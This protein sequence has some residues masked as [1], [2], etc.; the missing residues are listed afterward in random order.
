[1]RKR[2]QYTLEFK[3]E[4]QFIIGLRDHKG[5]HRCEGTAIEALED[6][7]L[8]CLP[9]DVV[10]SLREKYPRFFDHC[11]EILIREFV[12]G[13]IAQDCTAV[14]GTADSFKS[15]CTDYPDLIHRVP[16]PYLANF[17]RIPEKRLQHLLDNPI[18]LP[19]IGERRRPYKSTRE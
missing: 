1:V 3:K 18:Q 8:W 9:S 10:K 2:K 7:I 12:E 13:S 17:T 11:S 16:I 15:L 14:A 6:S 19:S 5:A 4:D